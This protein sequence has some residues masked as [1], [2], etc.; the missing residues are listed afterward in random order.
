MTATVTVQVTSSGAPVAGAA[1]VAAPASVPDDAAVIA[2][3][4]SA[5]ERARQ[6]TVWAHAPLNLP[7]H[8]VSACVP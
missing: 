7:G 1:V 3:R 4:P 6:V 8:E 5:P 2:A